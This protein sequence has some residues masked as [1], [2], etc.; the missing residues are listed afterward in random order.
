VE[1]LPSVLPP[2]SDVTRRTG[3]EHVPEPLLAAGSRVGGE[4]DVTVVLGFLE[5][6]RKKLH[7][8][9]ARFLRAGSRDPY[10]DPA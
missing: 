9:A 6:L 3:A 8:D 5:A 2:G 4:L 7:H 1:A 10:G